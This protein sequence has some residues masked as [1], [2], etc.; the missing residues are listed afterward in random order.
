MHVLLNKAAFLETVRWVAM[1]RLI[2]NLH[3][4]KH[5]KP[6]IPIVRVRKIAHLD[7]LVLSMNAKLKKK[8][9]FW[10]FPHNSR[11]INQFFFYQTVTYHY[12]SYIGLLTEMFRWCRRK[13]GFPIG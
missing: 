12:F 4:W 10:F 5:L 13:L 1:A 8:W 2:V 11:P 9:L 7:V 6:I 3:A